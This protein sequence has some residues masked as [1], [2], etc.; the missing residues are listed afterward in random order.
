MKS[1]I[2]TRLI[3]GGLI[4]GVVGGGLYYRHTEKVARENATRIVM[5]IS[6]MTCE[7]CKNKIEKNLTSLKGVYTAEVDLDSDTGAFEFNEKKVSKEAIT[8]AI[9]ELGYA[10]QIKKDS[11]R[12]QVIDYNIKFN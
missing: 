12:L 6:G 11:S 1:S 4:V 5:D 10:N 3:I 9:K 8:K 7:S 2:M